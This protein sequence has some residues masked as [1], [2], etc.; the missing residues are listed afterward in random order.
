M[1]RLNLVI[2]LSIFFCDT[3]FSNTVYKNYECKWDNKSSTPCLEIEGNL[4]NTSKFTKSGINKI[5]ISRKQIEESG[6]V[7][8]VDILKTISDVNITQSGPKG[9]QASMFLR[10]TNSN[11]TLVMINGVPIND[12]STTQGLHDFGVDFLN[13]IQQIEVYPGS[14]A[15]NFG[16]NS[17]GGAINIILTGDFKNYYKI[18]TDK[19]NNYDI[20]GNKTFIKDK[21]SLNFKLGTIRRET[22][23]V[24]GNPESEKDKVKNYSSNINYE[25]YFNDNLRI[26][27]SNYVRQTKS[28]YDGSAS[29]QEG[30]EG[31][32]KMAT[33]QF[34]LENFKENEKHE[35]KIYYNLYDRKYDEKGTIDKYE[36]EVIGLKY[37]FSK[38]I[39][40][41]LSL[42]IGTEYKY[43]WG[44]FQNNGSY[45]ASTKGHSEN[46]SIHGNIGYNFYS[47]SNISLFYRNDYH[48]YTGKNNTYKINLEQNF[49]KSNIGLSFMNGL[50]NP[51]LYELFGTDNFG[52]SGNR[53]LEP[54]KSDTL[55]VYSGIKIHKKSKVSLRAFKSRIK[56]NIE[57]ISNQY[58]NDNDN[59]DLN[60][61]GLNSSFNFKDNDLELNVF[62][63]L[64][65][66]KKENGSDTLRRPRKNYG[67]NIQKK[68]SNTIL[69]DFYINTLYNHYG[70]HLDTHSSTFST[71]EMD[72]VDLIDLQ[73]NKIL[74]S[75][76][77]FLKISN[78]LDEN[79]QK[80]HGYNQDK[81][82]FNFGVKF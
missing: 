12:Q 42:G 44:D 47:N 41:K 35:S 43:D 80:P 36:S 71:I 8:L 62:S 5:T 78:L 1:L 53:N 52:Y 23:S 73:I 30:Y 32:N 3:S 39:N 11:H 31:D 51:T 19:N 28:E 46:L 81:R 55:E 26:N 16:T 24:R 64:L 56:N 60:Q 20:S 37:D 18:S 15:T 29:D 50:R 69:G 14:S 10:G 79:Y 82:T 72:S 9:Q 49:S 61:S 22:I 34:G 33:F 67:L 54:E 70:K 68:M 45:E 63:S 48:K 40:T 59:I 74:R 2:I 57:Y 58:K 65:S 4:S 76:S 13:T 66:S 27:F 6:A 75:G 21:S 38:V 7:D 17:I 77:Y 25:K